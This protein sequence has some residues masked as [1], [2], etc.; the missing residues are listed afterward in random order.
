MDDSFFVFLGSEGG[1]TP[2]EPSRDEL[3]VLL[4]AN[5]PSASAVAPSRSGYASNRTTPLT[6]EGQLNKVKF[7]YAD[8]SYYLAPKPKAD[9]DHEVKA[10]VFD[11]AISKITG[12]VGG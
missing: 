4:G 11:D 5:R 6:Q 3:E 9:E 12:G 10:M 8:K 7:A 2:R 1:N